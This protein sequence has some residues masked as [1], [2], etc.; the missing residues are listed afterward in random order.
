MLLRGMGW[1]LLGVFLSSCTGG[2]PTDF[3]ALGGDAAGV[4]QAGTTDVAVSEVASSCEL[5]GD[6]VCCPGQVN[7]C[8][9][10]GLALLTCRAD[11]TGYE[12][13]PCT[14][15]DGGAT[16]CRYSLEKPD[17]YCSICDPGR[18]KCQDDDIVLACNEA[19]DAW[20]SYM[21]CQGRTTGNI[22]LSGGC[23]RLC[24]VN[25]KLNMYIGCD[26]WGADLDN[27]FVYQGELLDADTKQYSIVVSNPHSTYPA[28]VTISDINGAVLN[29]SDGVPFP[30]SLLQPGDLRIYNLNRKKEKNVE[31]TI[32]A[33]L[34][35]RVTA[36]IPITAYQFNPLENE[37]VYSND[38]SL[39]IPTNVLGKYYFVM[40]RE[41]TFD[42]LRGFLTV[43]AVQDGTRVTV[44]VTAPTLVG[45]NM[46]TDQ[47]IGHLEPGESVTYDLDA[48]DVLNI[49]TDE[50]GAD[51]TGSV[52]LATRNVA[53]FG[54][55]EA[56]NAPN[57]NHCDFDLGVCE[58]DGESP[59]DSHSDCTAK[60][61]NTCCA[62]H[63][64]QQLFPVKTWGLHYLASKTYPRNQELDVYRIIAA[65]N[66]TVVTLVPPVVSIPVLN[67]G[68]WVDFESKENFEI[69]AKRPIMV[70]QFLAA[71]DAPE[72]NVNGGQEGDAGI[73]DPAFI[74]LV[75]NE[76]FRNSY[77]FLAPNK[78][79]LDYITIVAPDGANVWFD[80][81]ELDEELVPF[82]CEPMDPDDFEYF[83]TGDYRTAKFLVSD[84][85]HRVTSDQSVAVYVYGYD[86]YVSYGYPAGLNIMDLGLI[87]EPEN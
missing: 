32:L 11:Q 40:T 31:G 22:C 38:A 67:R 29:E 46:K 1:L 58:Y 34:A 26:F 9:P 61:F 68:E 25:E 20:E 66:N 81:P 59:C 47:P 4:D 37:D 60:G 62:D 87:Q 36:S 57:T 78:Y 27:A 65:E 6:R 16:Q 63:L 80:C 49:E 71:Q 42:D 56:S 48:F 12:A 30:T 21:D 79:E 50:G 70:G 84:G 33:P 44:T 28:T 85:V 13:L 10:D 74:L 5:T 23:V 82:A 8:S 43:L 54:G 7:G 76:Q 77:V 52:V 64:E 53:V 3:D 15:E 14:G 41:Q 19:G 75:P 69:Y 18:R 39:L 83:G 2:T 24:D 51:L 35:Y 55:S 45:L 86:R 72:P 17:G 73:G